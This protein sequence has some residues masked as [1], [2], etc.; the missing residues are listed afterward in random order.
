MPCLW[1]IIGYVQIEGFFH[2]FVKS[3]RRVQTLGRMENRWID[4]WMDGRMDGWM[5]GSG[6]T[7]GG[8]D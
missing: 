1:R 7:E 6:G 8:T 2:G 3:K 4:G 5:D